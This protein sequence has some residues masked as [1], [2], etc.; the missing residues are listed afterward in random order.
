MDGNK[1]TH[2]LSMAAKEIRK[3]RN[4]LQQCLLDVYAKY[5][6]LGPEDVPDELWSEFDDLMARFAGWDGYVEDTIT[7]MSDTEVRDL[8]VEICALAERLGRQGR[9]LI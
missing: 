4:G 2:N 9:H 7:Q 5:L 3:S 1:V 6:R 8:G